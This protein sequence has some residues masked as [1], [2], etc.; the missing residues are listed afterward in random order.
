[1]EQPQKKV[2]EFHLN[3]FWTKFVVGLVG[4]EPTT[5]T[6]CKAHLASTG[7]FKLQNLIIPMMG[8]QT[9]ICILEPVVMLPAATAWASCC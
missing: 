6:R 9:R 1:V 5:F 4:F 2:R 8:L 3:T 7:F